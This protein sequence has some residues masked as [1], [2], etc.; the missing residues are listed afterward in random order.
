[1][2]RR[3]EHSFDFDPWTALT[4]TS[5]DRCCVQGDRGCAFFASEMKRGASARDDET[6]RST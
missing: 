3:V 4:H 6:G 2:T 5:K 1:L